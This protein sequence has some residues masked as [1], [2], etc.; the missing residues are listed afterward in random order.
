MVIFVKKD[1]KA[2]GVRLCV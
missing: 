1:I 2:E